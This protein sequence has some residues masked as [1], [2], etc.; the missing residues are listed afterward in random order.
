[1]VNN[2]KCDI[3]TFIV[4]KNNLNSEECNNQS[5]P[6]VW[7]NLEH[8]NPKKFENIP[9]SSEPSRHQSGNHGRK[10]TD[11]TR[12]HRL[13]CTCPTVLNDWQRIGSASSLMA[14]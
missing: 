8:K 13:P 3:R 14:E 11:H 5:K 4:A 12:V 6:G 10:P 7:K 2:S 9:S 1:M